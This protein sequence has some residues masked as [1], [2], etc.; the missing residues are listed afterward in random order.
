M[1]HAIAKVRSN[2]KTIAIE[3]TQNWCRVRNVLV[4]M[5][6]TLFDE[7]PTVK[8]LQFYDCPSYLYIFLLHYREDFIA[9][10]KSLFKKCDKLIKTMSINVLNHVSTVPKLAS[11]YWQ[12]YTCTVSFYLCFPVWISN[13]EMLMIGI[14]SYERRFA[15]D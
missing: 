1:Q 5:S 6:A 13:F 15:G 9:K 11:V 12:P 2:G 14:I 7:W 4:Q 10:T 8:L 3:E